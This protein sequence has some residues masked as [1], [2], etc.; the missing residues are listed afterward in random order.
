MTFGSATVTD[1]PTRLAAVSDG[2]WPGGVRFGVDVVHEGG[3]DV[4]LAFDADLTAVAGPGVWVLGPGEHLLLDAPMV[5]DRIGRDAA[6]YA[7]TAGG[8]AGVNYR[9]G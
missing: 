8:A 3:P 6:L 9:A 4:F 1:A 7:R 5:T 2:P